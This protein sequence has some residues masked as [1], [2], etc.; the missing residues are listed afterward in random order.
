[1]GS[2]DFALLAIIFVVWHKGEEVFPP[3]PVHRVIVT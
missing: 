1:M 2:H 3:E